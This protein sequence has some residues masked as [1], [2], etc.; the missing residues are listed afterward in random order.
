M[1]KAIY[2]RLAGPLGKEDAK[3]I[4][5]LFEQNKRIEAE[6]AFIASLPDQDIPH[7]PISG[8]KVNGISAK[9]LYRRYEIEPFSGYVFLIFL[10]IDFEESMEKIKKEIKKRISPPVFAASGFDGSLIIRYGG[11][12]IRKEENGRLYDIPIS[13]ERARKMAEGDM[14]PGAKACERLVNLGLLEYLMLWCDLEDHQAR[15]ALYRLRPVKYEL[16]DTIMTDDFPENAI[17]QSGHTAKEL[18]YE[19]DLSLF[20]SYA[21]MAWLAEDEEAALKSLERRK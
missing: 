3:N 15:N 1:D 14:M 17:E 16:Y 11:Y 20:E 13:T 21:Y 2:E 12:H 5:S 10:Y 8:I 7:F 6:A 4:A 9:D 19:K 18:F